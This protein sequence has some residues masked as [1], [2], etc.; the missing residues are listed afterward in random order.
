MREREKRKMRERER[1]RE[2]KREEVISIDWTNGCEVNH[3]EREGGNTFMRRREDKTSSIRFRF[4][5]VVI[6]GPKSSSPAYLEEGESVWEKDLPINWERGRGRSEERGR[7]RE[8]G[9]EG[10]RERGPEGLVDSEVRDE[11]I[12]LSAVSDFPSEWGILRPSVD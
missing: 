4:S 10:E 3:V 1:K 12:I 5:S 6:S 11:H 2:R 9:R 8:S 7:E